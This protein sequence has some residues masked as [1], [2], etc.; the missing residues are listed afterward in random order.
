MSTNSPAQYETL[1]QAAERL[2]MGVSTLRRWI[3]EGKLTAYRLNS[4]VVRL[5]VSEVDAMM[6]AAATNQWG[7]AA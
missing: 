7:G 6:Q 5:K 1:K 2:E 4:R 3:A